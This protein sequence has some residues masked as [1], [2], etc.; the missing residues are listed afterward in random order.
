MY[1]LVLKDE[2]IA[3]IDTIA[4]VSAGKMAEALSKWIRTQII[5]NSSNASI[6]HYSRLLEPLTSPEDIISAILVGV[7][8]NTTGNLIFLFD[9]NST[10]SIIKKILHREIGS[11]LGW[12]HITR[13]VM[14][15]TGNII[16]TAFLNGIATSLNLELYP[17]S[18]I[19]TC[20]YSGAILETM[21]A[22]VAMKGE[23]ALSCQISFR[24]SN[25]E[26]AGVFAMLPE[27]I[28]VW[29]RV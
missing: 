6:V 8:G 23:Y 27:D 4:K 21:M 18:P 22:H 3:R 12:D 14:E 15:E 5:V 25:D 13:S 16:G 28:S 17:S 26:M 7:T 11:M 10:L 1:P 2:Q 9:E 20:D 24:S 29:E 19:V